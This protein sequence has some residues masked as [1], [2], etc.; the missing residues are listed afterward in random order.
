M[1]RFL[2]FNKD[3]VSDDRLVKWFSGQ[4]YI[5]INESDSLYYLESQNGIK[6]AIEKKLENKSYFI[7]TEKADNNEQRM[8]IS[9]QKQTV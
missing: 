8:D 2:V 9:N 1:N 7:L 3:I 5:I 4:K 6:L